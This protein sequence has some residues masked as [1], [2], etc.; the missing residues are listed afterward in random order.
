LQKSEI[1]IP[2]EAGI[3]SFQEFLDARFCRGDIFFE[4]CN[5]LMRKRIFPYLALLVVTLLSGCAVVP[6]LPFVPVIGSAYQGYV[7]WKG[8]E[9]TKYYAFD[10][11]TINRAVMSASDRLKLESTLIKSVPQEGYSLKTKGKVQMHIDILPFEKHVTI[12]VIR[13]PILGNKHY[14]QL[15][16]SLIDDNLPK[17]TAANEEQTQ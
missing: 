3:Q 5:N 16:Y 12:V 11:D 9:A 1:V 15:F 14:V 7:I 8:G 13:I 6:F 17:S 4:F 10:L 2:V